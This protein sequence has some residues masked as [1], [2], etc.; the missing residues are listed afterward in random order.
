VPDAFYRLTPSRSPLLL[1]SGGL[2]PATPPRHAAR[3]AAALGPKAQSIV[4]PNAGH[5][6]MRLGCMREVIF[7]FIDAPDPA[8]ESPVDASCAT[9]VPRPPAFRPVDPHASAPR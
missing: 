7:R 1:L 2:D 5:G 8:V 4:V 3:V 6:V 9:R